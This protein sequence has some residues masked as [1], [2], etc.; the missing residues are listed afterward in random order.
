MSK[1]QI[2]FYVVWEGSKTR[3]LHSW[4]ECKSAIHGY[5]GAK[6]KSFKTLELAEKA[7]SENYEDYKGR[8]FFETTLSKEKLS[9]IGSPIMDSVSVDAACSGNPGTVEYQCV[10]TSSHNQLFYYGP[11]HEC[12]NNIGE[13]LGLVHA[14][15]HMKLIGDLRPI[16]TDSKT[17]ISWVRKRT[18]KTK[19][20]PS[21][22]NTKSFE[23]LNRAIIWLKENDISNN[24]LKWETQ[25]WG[26]IPADFGRK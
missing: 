25:A 5:K 21:D 10:D 7:F 17:A 24:I 9:I 19:L 22:K 2:K 13:F 23:L 11:L 6:Y 3:I 15:A 4:D 20:I 1:K 14:L 8:T 16:Y 12:T 26:E 18:F